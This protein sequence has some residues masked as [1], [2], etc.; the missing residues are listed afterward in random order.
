MSAVDVARLCAVTGGLSVLLNDYD[1]SKPFPITFTL[2]L[3]Q[4]LC[5]TD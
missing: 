2:G 4:N 5:C 3:Q 1:E